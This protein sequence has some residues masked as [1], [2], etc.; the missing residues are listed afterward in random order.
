MNAP[1][2]FPSLDVFFAAF[3]GNVGG[4]ISYVDAGLRYRFVSGSKDPSGI[5]LGTLIASSASVVTAIFVARWL[6]RSPNYRVI[7]KQPAVPST[8]E[9]GTANDGGGAT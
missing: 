6:S 7:V 9:G 5:I 4:L 8:T 2:G 3:T 1:A